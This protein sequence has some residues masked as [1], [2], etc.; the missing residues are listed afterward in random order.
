M[1]ATKKIWFITGISRG[2]GKALAEAAL[3]LGH[4]VIGTT[5]SGT[6]D[7]ERSKGR[8]HVLPLD[9]TDRE[10]VFATVKKAYDLYWRLDV[11]VNNAGYGLLGAMETTAPDEFNEVMN[12]NFFGT[13]NVM[14]ASLPFMRAQ[15]S[16]HIVNLSSIA[17]LAPVGG[18]AFYA[19]AKFAVEGLSTAV[20]HEVR[21]L[22]IKVTVVEPG[23]FRTDFLTDSSIRYT[24]ESIDDYAGSAGQVRTLLENMNGNQP[25]D[26]LKA[27]E[28]IIEAVYSEAPPLHLVLGQDAFNRVSSHTEA[29]HQE[30]DKWKRLTLSTDYP[31][32]ATKCKE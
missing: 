29:F 6:A 22:G 23:A 10:Q 28:A 5:R 4:T 3:L 8:L 12:V 30:L 26:P 7:I 17:G 25:G 16:G 2:L 32:L 13:V 15:H 9:V 11:V 21:D 14:Q 1:E 18:Y 20:A 27:A 24:T 31:Q 19:A